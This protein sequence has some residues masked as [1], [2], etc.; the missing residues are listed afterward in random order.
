LSYEDFYN[1][2]GNKV[3]DVMFGTNSEPSENL[4]KR[5]TIPKHVRFLVWQKYNR[6]SL[7]GKCFVCKSPIHTILSKLDTIKRFLKA[8][9][10]TFPI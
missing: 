9:A 1:D 2:L 10:I 8:E 5:K 6:N 3:N 7:I 4:R